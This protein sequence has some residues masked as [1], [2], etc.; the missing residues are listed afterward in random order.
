MSIL[1]TTYQAGR[2]VM[3]RNDG[4]VLNTH[5]RNFPKPMGLALTPNR[6]AIG[7]DNDIREFHN[8]PAVGTKLEPIKYL[9]G[10]KEFFSFAHPVDFAILG[11]G[12]PVSFLRIDD[13]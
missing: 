11:L 1:L 6:L 9:T 2:L 7:C 8:V 12:D 3:L 5:F 10:S 4:G 13:T